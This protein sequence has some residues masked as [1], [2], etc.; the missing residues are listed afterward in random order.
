MNTDLYAIVVVPLSTEDGGG[1]AAHV[2]DLPGCM[3][4]GDTQEEAVANVKEAIL[5]W[6]D[7]WE[8]LGREVP[9]PGMAVE[10]VRDRDHKLMEAL[11]AAM[12]YGDHADGRIDDLEKQL[13]VLID[14]MS[15]EGLS[16]SFAGQVVIAARVLNPLCH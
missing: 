13:Q 7:A 8:E 15:N 10:R 12:A 4:D 5:S 1:F 16:A 2:P 3:S 6:I 9:H 14:H 11:K